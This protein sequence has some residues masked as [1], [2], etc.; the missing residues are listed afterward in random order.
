VKPKKKYIYRRYL[1]SRTI[2]C[3]DRRLLILRRPLRHARYHSASFRP[4]NKRL[5]TEF[6]LRETNPSRRSETNVLVT[7]S[8]CRYTTHVILITTP[9]PAPL[10]KKTRLP[11]SHQTAPHHPVPATSSNLHQ[12]RLTFFV[13]KLKPHHLPFK[14]SKLAKL[15]C[16]YDS[17]LWLQTPRGKSPVTTR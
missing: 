7:T 17:A 6:S 3:Q 4:R 16:P 1:R 8:P 14:R 10:K 15:R 13:T 9:Q 11:N 12:G 2:L 5:P